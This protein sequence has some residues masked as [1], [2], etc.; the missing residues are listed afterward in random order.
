[1]LNAK[2]KSDQFLKSKEVQTFNQKMQSNPGNFLQNAWELSYSTNMNTLQSIST[3]A[4]AMYNQLKTDPFYR[5]QVTMKISL[6]IATLFMGVGEVGS[7]SDAVKV[8]TTAER[9]AEPPPQ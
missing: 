6:D 4:T 5:G 8:A 7:A 1:M 2:D 9:G 3:T